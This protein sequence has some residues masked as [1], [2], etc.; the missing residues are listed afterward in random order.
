MT[1]CLYMSR[2]LLTVRYQYGMLDD[3]TR[4]HVI[5]HLIRE[6]VSCGKS[7]L[8]TSIIGSND[9]LEPGT[10]PAEMG[11]VHNLIQKDRVLIAVGLMFIMRYLN[12]SYRYYLLVF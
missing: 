4:F 11:A 2:S 3:G 8:A 10:A 12:H 6:T 5:S 9:S 7:L 1:Y